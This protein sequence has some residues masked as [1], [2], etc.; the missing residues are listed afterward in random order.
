MFQPA[1]MLWAM[2]PADR[3]AKWA[4]KAIKEKKGECGALMIIEIACGSSPDHLVAVRKAYSTR[5]SRSLEEEI[6]FTSAF[7]EPMREVCT[8]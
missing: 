6:A 4:H 2:D 7:K 5:Y 8:S 1:L 3:D